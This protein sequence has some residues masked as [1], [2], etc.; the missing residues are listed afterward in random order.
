M[1]YN[2]NEISDTNKDIEF[3]NLESRIVHESYK[4]IIT[5]SININVQIKNNIVYLEINNDKLLKINHANH[6][7]EEGSKILIS[8]SN[9][10]YIND[11]NDN[12]ITAVPN[13]IIN[14]EQII[15]KIIDINNYLIK[16]D[17]FNTISIS[18]NKDEI[19]IIN[20]KYK[21]KFRLEFDKKDTLGNLIGFRNVGQNNSITHYHTEIS[22]TTPY[23]NELKMHNNKIKIM[24]NN[25]IY[26]NPINYILLSCNFFYTNGNNNTTIKINN[27][28]YITIAKIY[29]N[30][31][32]GVVYNNHINLNSKFDFIIQKL[33]NIEFIF[34]DRD[35]NLYDFGNIEHSFVLKFDIENI[36][37]KNTFINS[38]TGLSN[39]NTNKQR[40]YVSNLVK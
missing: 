3:I 19:N 40:V 37:D 18:N 25:R 15:Y 12:L 9:N 35:Y 14:K 30:N 31:L 16:L 4:D 8:N 24:Q 21:L 11:S 36:L 39:V 13:N 38:Q 33:D 27:S 28:N 29:L 23:I 5:F 17:T 7:L 10:I 1:I 26:L 2:N 32:G 22:N 20:I 34:H 6:N